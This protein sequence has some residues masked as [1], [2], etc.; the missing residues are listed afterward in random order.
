LF[1]LNILLL[2]LSILAVYIPLNTLTEEGLVNALPCFAFGALCFAVLFGLVKYRRLSARRPRLA[3]TVCYW[4][5][6]PALLFGTIQASGAFDL[7]V[8]FALFVSAVYAFIYW[9]LGVCGA[10]LGVASAM[11]RE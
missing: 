5:L 7:G 10:F 8:L 6:Y 3:R 4:M 11:E 2:N 9:V 1:G